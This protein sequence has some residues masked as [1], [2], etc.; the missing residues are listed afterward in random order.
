MASPGEIDIQG[1]WSMKFLAVFSIEPQDGARRLL[2]EAEEGQAGLGDD[3]L[4]MVSVACTISGD[5]MFGSTWR[6]MIQRCGRP[7]ERAPST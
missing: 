1:A 4:A 6:I 7:I 3:R 5:I 2:A